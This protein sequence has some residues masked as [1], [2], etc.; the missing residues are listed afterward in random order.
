[1]KQTSSKE[2]TISFLNSSMFTAEIG[3]SGSIDFQ[4]T[5][6]GGM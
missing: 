1:M 5:F 6:S 4:L 2:V 3:Q